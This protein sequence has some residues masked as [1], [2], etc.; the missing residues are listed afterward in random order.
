[1]HGIQSGMEETN[2][3]E[4]VEVHHSRHTSNLQM[5]N[6]DDVFDLDEMGGHT[7]EE[8][9]SYSIEC[10]DIFASINKALVYYKD[11]TQDTSP[12][13][14]DE[15]PENSKQ[16]TLVL[17]LDGTLVHGDILEIDDYDDKFDVFF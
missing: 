15:Y 11:H 7:E 5:E 1:M 4:E 8:L 16:Y 13:L 10:F 12:L 9:F 2:E 17:D 6:I 14:E 3:N